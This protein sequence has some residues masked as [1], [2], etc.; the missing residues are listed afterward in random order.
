MPP[1]EPIARSPRAVS[2]YAL[3][4]R[5][6]VRQG[7]E[8]HSA[9]IAWRHESERDEIFVMTP[10][11]QGVAELTRD[12][13]GARLTTADR[14]EL[15]APDWESLSAQVFGFSLPLS[16]LPRWITG[17]A[18]AADDGWRADYLD[19]DSAAADALPTLIELK[20]DDIELRLR[21]DEWSEVR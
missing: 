14:K 15:V 18:P 1:G 13:A 21:V 8:R 7:E 10:L 11:G 20:R 9:R 6:S 16:D 2:A 4:G 19:Y 12:A 3:E 17:H 5:L